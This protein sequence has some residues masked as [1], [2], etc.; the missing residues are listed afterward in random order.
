MEIF[1]E[2][3]NKLNEIIWGPVTLGVLLIVGILFSVMTKFFQIRGI[4]LWFSKTIG[5]AFKKGKN[6]GVSAF[7]AMSTA[8]SGCMG[9]GNI[10]GVATAVA[11]GGPGAV[12]WMWVS[13][14]LGMMTAFAENV[15]AIKF[16]Q[17]DENGIFYGGPMYYIEKG[18][19]S[20]WLA[21]LFSVFCL[22]ASFGIGNL[23]QSNSVA[24]VVNTTVN[25]DNIYTSVILAVLVGIVI[26]GGIK[27]L[28]KVTSTI[29]PFMVLLYVISGIVVISFN[30]GNLGNVFNSIFMGAFGFEQA[31]GG[32]SGALILNAMRT[33]VSRGVFSNEAGMGSSAIAHGASNTK[34]PV[35]QGMWGIFQVFVDTMLG[36]SITA[37]VIL[38]TGAL[39]SGKEGVELTSYA[40]SSV[41]RIGGEIIIFIN[42]I[43]L[44]FSTLITWEYYGEQSLKYLTKG[45]GSLVYKLIFCAVIIFGGVM[46]IDIVWN[47]SDTLNGLMII[48]NII[49]L[50]ILSPIVK[51]EF[52]KYM[53][54]KTQKQEI[55]D[56]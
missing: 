43:L 15:L 45:K 1:N 32:I 36:C 9:T 8:L 4:G 33:G 51:K 10:V 30:A 20:K 27:R 55:I 22:G 42:I 31:V 29:V 44:A 18:L 38:S 52:K 13:A 26:F 6:T 40:F 23:T 47:I 49:A 3:N 14:F 48:P 17:Q 56:V 2:I 34:E 35:V 12:F 54:R 53:G 37:L 5:R 50:F 16:R 46:K 39:G 11:I 7:E 21:V 19:K 41:F 28:V 25:V 24:N